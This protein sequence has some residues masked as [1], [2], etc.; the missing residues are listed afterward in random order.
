MAIVDKL[1]KAAIQFPSG[2]NTAAAPFH[3]LSISMIA[4]SVDIHLCHFRFHSLLPV[5]VHFIESLPAPH[6]KRLYVENIAQY[7]GKR[8]LVPSAAG[9]YLVIARHGPAIDQLC[10]TQGLS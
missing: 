8:A 3:L 4:P 6:R 7:P 5:E 1:D 2:N 9:I 10:S